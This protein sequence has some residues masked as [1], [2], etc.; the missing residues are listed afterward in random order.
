MEYVSY[1][2]TDIIKTDLAF[3]VC[4]LTSI[5]SILPHKS[6]IKVWESKEKHL[7]KSWNSWKKISLLFDRNWRTW[8][9]LPSAN[10]QLARVLSKWTRRQ[11]YQVHLATIL[12]ILTKRRRIFKYRPQCIDKPRV[13][14]DVYVI[15]IEHT[16]PEHQNWYKISSDHYL[17]DTPTPQ[18]TENHA[19]RNSAS[20]S[21][22]VF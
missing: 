20:N 1:E 18:L 16:E 13:M 14:Q 15:A 5:E 22:S 4:V 19:T 11:G 21:D 12:H 6:F 10:W 9:H 17:S 7:L 3:P 2:L 8:K